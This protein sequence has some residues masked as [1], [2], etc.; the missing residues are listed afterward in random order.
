MSNYLS[1]DKHE[2]MVRL[3]SEGHSLS[4]IARLI[5]CSRNTVMKHLDSEAVKAL[6]YKGGPVLDIDIRDD[7]SLARV[8]IKAM[9]QGGSAQQVQA[10][11][12]AL[13]LRAEQTSGNPASEPMTEE[14]DVEFKRYLRE[15]VYTDMCN[16][17]REKAVNKQVIAAAPAETVN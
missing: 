6:T 12:A 9:E 14:E 7:E 15:D 2:K 13:K 3:K 8:L 5:P 11:I 10:V 17:C 1:G 16:E 4:E